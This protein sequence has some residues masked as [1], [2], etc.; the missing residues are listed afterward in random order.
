MTYTSTV[1]SKGTITLP[2][3]LRSQLGIKEGDKVEISL[4]GNKIVTVPQIGWD[5]F[6]SD[7]YDFGGKARKA[8]KS[9]TK[10]QLVTNA[11]IAAAVNE[12]RKHRHAKS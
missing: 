5:E 12:V 6:F 10:K 8:M 2:A 11:D 4:Q 3:A 1:T 7:E 9:G